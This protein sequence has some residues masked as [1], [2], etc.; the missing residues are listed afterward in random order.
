MAES[1]EIEDAILVNILDKNIKDIIILIIKKS[2][3]STEMW[4]LLLSYGSEKGVP[5][6][7]LLLTIEAIHYLCEMTMDN[8]YHNDHDL[9]F[10]TTHGFDPYNNGIVASKSALFTPPHCNIVKIIKFFNV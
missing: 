9:L 6:K 1:P 4:D 8:T 5:I 10:L 2:A 3:V 7:L